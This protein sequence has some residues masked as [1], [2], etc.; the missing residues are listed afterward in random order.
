MSN[1]FIYEKAL[2]EAVKRIRMEYTYKCKDFN[3]KCHECQMHLAS[4]IMEDEL[5]LT[6]YFN[7]VKGQKAEEEIEKFLKGFAYK[8][9]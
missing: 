4:N 6:S 1:K 5:I 3:M 7:S 9:K 2:K 8:K